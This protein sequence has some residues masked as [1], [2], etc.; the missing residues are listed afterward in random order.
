MIQYIKELKV[1]LENGDI[2]GALSLIDEWKE[3][4]DFESHLALDSLLYKWHD[5]TAIVGEL[6]PFCTVYECKDCPLPRDFCDY[7]QDRGRS[8]ISSLNPDL[9]VEKLKRYHEEE[10]KKILDILESFMMRPIRELDKY[11]VKYLNAPLH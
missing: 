4:D 8:L 2:T 1:Y 10:Y 7:T 9:T 3:T 5:D 6:C 11:T